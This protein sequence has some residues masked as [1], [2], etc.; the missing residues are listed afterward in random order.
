MA[1]KR[2]L[3]LAGL[4]RILTRA[5]R[6]KK[7]VLTNGVFDL[8][9]MGHV[10]YLEDA[11][12]LGDILV[13]AVNNDA[14]VRALKGP[15]RPINSAAA[16]AKVLTGLRAVDFATIF[17]GERATKVIRELAPDIYVKGG[18]Y[19]AATLNPEEKKA[20]EDVGAKIVILQ[21]VKGFSTTKTIKHLKKK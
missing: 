18:D 1:S 16:R 2:V 15:T 14:S 12:S 21:F 6:G 3:E 20:L 10:T 7:V 13:V 9:H 5:R 11:K 17:S 8:L 4:K 19:T